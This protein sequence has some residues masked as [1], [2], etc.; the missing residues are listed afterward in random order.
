[1]RD[2]VFKIVK[3]QVENFIHLHSKDASSKASETLV[4]YRKTSLCHNQEDLIYFKII[5]SLIQTENRGEAFW[6]TRLKSVQ[7][8]HIF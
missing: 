2:E 5:N 8:P 7:V 6:N 4:S 3:I 1:M